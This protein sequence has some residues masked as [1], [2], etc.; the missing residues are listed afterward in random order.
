MLK[1][2]ERKPLVDLSNKGLKLRL[3]T[4]LN[5]IIFIAEIENTSTKTIAPYD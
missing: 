3:Q 5:H 1:R 4:L 2:N